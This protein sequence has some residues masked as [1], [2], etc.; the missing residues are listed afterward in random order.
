[1]NAS[2]PEQSPIASNAAI[3]PDEVD[4]TNCEAAPRTK[5]LEIVPRIS[6]QGSLLE[7]LF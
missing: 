6:D 2:D 3:E 7:G 5:I 4:S 1:M